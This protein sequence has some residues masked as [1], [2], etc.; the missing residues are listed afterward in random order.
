MPYHVE[1]ADGVK[2]AAALLEQAAGSGRGRGLEGIPAGPR[3]RPAHRRLSGQRPCLARHEDEPHRPRD[4]PDR[5]LRGPAVR[6]Q[7]VRTRRTCWS[8]T[9]SGADG[10]HATRPCCRNCS[11]ACRCRSAYKAEKPGTD[12]DLN[13]YDVL[14]YAGDC[15]AGSKTIAINLP[16]DEQVQ[17]EKGTRR[18]QLKNAMRA[19]FDKIMVPIA[20]ELI[21][22]EQREHVTFDAFFAR[23]DVPRGRA[24]SRHQEHD[25]RQGHGS[26]R[27]QGTRRAASRKARPTSSAST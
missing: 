14:Y 10:S 24:R 2:R 19:K 23:H 17:L 7:G 26:R 13:A 11:A 21:V 4:R 20:D 18:L 9:W 25:R 8:R 27:A 5:D 15:N 3:H 6:L 22:P 1:Y 16:N 12:S